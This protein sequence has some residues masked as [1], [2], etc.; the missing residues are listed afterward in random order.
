MH[1]NFNRIFLSLVNSL[2]LI[3]GILPKS[4]DYFEFNYHF[5]YRFDSKPNSPCWCNYLKIA[6]HNSIKL[7]EEKYGKENLYS[8]T[9]FT[10]SGRNRKLESRLLRSL[11]DKSPFRIAIM[12]GSYSLPVHPYHNA[13]AFNVSRWLNS[14]LSVSSCN[15][16]EIISIT[17]HT[18]NCKDPST[19]DDY[20]PG[21]PSSHFINPGSVFCHNL[22][23]NPEHEASFHD[24]KPLDDICDNTIPPKRKCTVFGGSGPH[25]TSIMGSKGGTNTNDGIWN[26]ET[27][28]D[29]SIDVLFWDYGVNDHADSY[30]HG[31]FING[32]FERA[33]HI[34]PNISAFGS[35]YWVD[36]LDNAA[37]E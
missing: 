26:L 9:I 29:E 18:L 36:T 33:A 15:I 34:F 4:F 8:S 37:S 2:L 21:C 28:G 30:S 25:A 23:D 31:S 7:L 6:V 14:V 11:N 12:G 5:N 3:N 24:A 35:V 19:I 16:T 22:A 17:N 1:V 13:W 32:F 27:I 10:S 20:F